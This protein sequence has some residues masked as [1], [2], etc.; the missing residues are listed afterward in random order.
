MTNYPIPDGVSFADLQGFMQKAQPEKSAEL[1]AGK[2]QAEVEAIAE[3]AIMDTIAECEDPII[4]K[5]MA[6][7]IMANLGDWHSLMA[8]HQAESGDMETAAAYMADL[9]QIRSAYLLLRTVSVH[10]DDFT[11]SSGE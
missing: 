6:L 2:T 4:H 5:V 11:V 8:Q 9:G 7:K 1:Y 3:K 10:Q